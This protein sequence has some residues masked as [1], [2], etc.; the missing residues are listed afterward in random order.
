M[1]FRIL[2]GVPEMQALWERLQ[3]ESVSK[4]LSADD[5]KLYKRLAKAVLLLESN[6]RYP[7]LQTHEIEPLSRRYG[8]K[9]WQSYLQN[10]TPAAGR[11]FWVYAPTQGD[12]TIIGLEPHPNDHKQHG[13]AMIKLSDLP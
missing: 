5:T 9:V 13:Y 1:K 4:T 2:F 3:Q 12:I 10:N 11:I 8:Q 6:P 7:G